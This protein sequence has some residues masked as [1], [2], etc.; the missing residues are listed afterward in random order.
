MKIISLI[1]KDLK[2]LKRDPRTLFLIIVVPLILLFILGNIFTTNNIGDSSGVKIGLCDLDQENTKNLNLKLFDITNL[3]KQRCNDARHLVSS[4]K[5]R[6]VAIIPKDFTY[7]INNGR[8][9]EITIY[10]DNSKSQI[11]ILVID[12]FKAFVQD[13]NGD[14]GTEFID[15]AWISLN[16][17]NSNLKIIISN[18]EKAKLVAEET[19]KELDYLND[20]ISGLNETELDL[21]I[22]KLNYTIGNSNSINSKLANELINISK[23]LRSDYNSCIT[24]F[25]KKICSYFNSSADSLDNISKYLVKNDIKFNASEIL[26]FK[27]DLKTKIIELNNSAY[28]YSD[29]I[30]TLTNDLKETS[31]LLD[32][33]TSKD[34]KN[35]VSAVS[36]NENMVFGNKSY[37]EFLSP[38]LVM[39]ILLFT[40]ILI[41]SSN[42]VSER[43]GGTMAR[44]L[45]SPTTIPSLLVSKTLYF[46][47]LSIIEISL[48]GLLLLFMG[49]SLQLNTQILLIISLGSICFILLG[50]FVGSISVSEN[51]SLLTSL[52]IIL[53]MFFL[54]NLFFP[55]EVM[56]EFM[57]FVG[58]NLPLTLS[59]EGLGKAI[60]YA[61]QV[62][63]V[64]Y[65]KLI[66]T[67]IIL[68]ILAYIGIKR[69]PTP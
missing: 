19:K 29:S 2:L 65:I 41:A 12:S 58:K 18:L 16:D 27:N 59:I 51:N 60:F 68:F 13:L 61:V 43:N 48:M 14:I 47:L 4:G 69:K 45:L 55:F 39:I 20:R 38:G 6:A 17:L 32:E 26:N 11:F 67:A 33:Y 44:T 8:G 57:Q 21:T 28:T 42:V 53:P 9:S 63:Y 66:I 40:I 25:N 3:D 35:I 46:F 49:I 36:L 1:K 56:P 22:I 7:D 24:E 50:L 34:P 31:K 10:V 64:I 30:I 15:N 62:D 54:S 5:F 23:E 37:F 52:V